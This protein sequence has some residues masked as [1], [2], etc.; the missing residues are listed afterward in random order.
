MATV[1]IGV[2]LHASRLVA[3]IIK[4]S[5]DDVLERSDISISTEDIAT[6]FI[7]LLTPET[8]ILVEASSCTFTFIDMVKPYV[9]KAIAVNPSD[10]KALYVTG[11]KN[12][13]IDAKKL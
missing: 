4:R 5:I 12:D 8:Y 1:Y 2:D 11:K 7:S 6:K 10:F 3:H 9:K 13:R